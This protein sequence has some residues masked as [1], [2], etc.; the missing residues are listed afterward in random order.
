MPCCR[1]FRLGCTLVLLAAGLTGFARETQNVFIV[2]IDGL[3]SNEGFESGRTNLPFISDSLR[4]LGTLYTQFYNTGVTITN[5]AQSTIVTGASQLLYNNAGIETQIRPREPTIGEYYRKE[6]GLPSDKAVFISGKS[7]I[8]R[9]PVSTMPGYGYAWA[10]SI[11]LN[12]WGDLA[13]WDSVCS[14]TAR[15]HPSLCYV[16]LGQVDDASHTGDT[17]CYIGS[18]RQ[19]DS[20]VF[21]LWKF[22][23]SDSAYRDHT[24]LIVTSDHGRHDD[25]HGGWKDHGCTCHGCRHVLFLALGPDIKADTVVTD[26]RAQIDIAPTVGCL[27]DFDTPFVQGTVLT[28]MLRPCFPTPDPRSPGPFLDDHNLSNSAGASRACDIA[29]AR[30]V[31]HCAYADNSNGSWQILHT[32][33][34]DR[35]NYWSSAQPLF[36]GNDDYTEPVLAVIDSTTLFAAALVRRWSA[37]DTTYFWALSGRRSTDN[38]T[39]W[40]PA[41][42]IE[43]LGMVSCRPALCA[44][45]QRVGVTA[46]LTWGLGFSLS[47]N[48]G[49]TFSPAEF[50]SSFAPHFPQ[51]PAAAMLDTQSVIVWQGL[52]PTF[53]PDSANVHN[54]WLGYSPRRG[55]P[56]L[57]THNQSTNYSYL[58]TLAAESPGVL[59]LAYANLPDAG[60]GNNWQV[61]YR[62]GTALG[63]TWSASM[64]LSG[65]EVGYSPSICRYGDGRLGCAWAAFSDEQW[66]IDAA[67][68]ADDGLTW[69]LPFAVSGPQDFTTEPRLVMDDDTC[70]AA[71]QDN[72]SGN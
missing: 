52:V 15:N 35:G 5:S 26:R 34:T 48:R 47:T 27:L 3:R 59:H 41:F 13:T 30:G 49:A 17:S 38:G 43:S 23:Q 20:L 63:D 4:P 55:C 53:G 29:L 58:P 10:P 36:S 61:V 54:I 68:S 8:W 71:W 22:I 66:H 16:L 69:S 28:E 65:S 31:L 33:S 9:Y 14:V 39:T 60:M 21:E 62:R 45:G 37:M 7:A 11:V 25:R 19:A 12:S 32:R 51:A 6:T 70:F 44:S 42:Q 56:R 2:N 64:P 40:Q 24:A 18:I 46:L 72:R 57:L 67:V 50:V 1:Q